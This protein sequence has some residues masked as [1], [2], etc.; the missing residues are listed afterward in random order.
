MDRSRTIII[1]ILAAGAFVIGPLAVAVAIILYVWMPTLFLFK[2][3]VTT[4]IIWAVL[5]GFSYVLGDLAEWR[6]P[7]GKQNE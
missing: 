1:G 2:F 4:A 7:E 6:P 5:F 3:I